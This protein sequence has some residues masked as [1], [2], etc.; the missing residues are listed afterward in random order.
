MV[1]ESTSQRAGLYA[2]WEL[3]FVRRQPLLTENIK[4]NLRTKV[5]ICSSSPNQSLDLQLADV[6]LVMPNLHKTQCWAFVYV[7]PIVLYHNCAF[8][9]SGSIPLVLSLQ[10]GSH[11]QS[12][13]PTQPNFVQFLSRS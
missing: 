4:L 8:S 9:Q 3:L 12:S 10:N 11:C 13:P 5:E 2:G 1:G 6:L 7:S